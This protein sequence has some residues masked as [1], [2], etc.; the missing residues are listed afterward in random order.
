MARVSEVKFFLDPGS[1]ALQIALFAESLP[2]CP[3]FWLK[4]IDASELQ[5][6]RLP[7]NCQLECKYPIQ[8]VGRQ[9]FDL[10]NSEYDALVPADSAPAFSAPPPRT[11]TSPAPVSTPAAAPAPAPV[12]A[13]PATAS[14][15]SAAT[16]A[17]VANGSEA[18]S[19]N[20]EIAANWLQKLVDTLTGRRAKK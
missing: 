5:F 8:H 19:E 11:E 10:P 3:E 20:S 15:G 17:P 9:P 14:N 4:N 16:S 13:A 1:G 2:Q 6:D 12:A 7:E 18:P